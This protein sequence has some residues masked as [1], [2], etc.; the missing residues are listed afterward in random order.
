MEDEPD[1][2]KADETEKNKKQIK[3]DDQR[4]KDSLLQVRKAEAILPQNKKKTEA[5]DSTQNKN[6]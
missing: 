5:K 1:L 4:R 3:E 2:V 6:E